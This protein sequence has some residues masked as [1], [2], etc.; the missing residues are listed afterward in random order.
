[1]EHH[2]II[3]VGRLELIHTASKLT[4]RI[5]LKLHILQSVLKVHL[6]SNESSGSVVMEGAKAVF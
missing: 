6:L 4:A 1:M 2:E 3:Q 5:H